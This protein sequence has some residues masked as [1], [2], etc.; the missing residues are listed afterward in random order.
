MGKS[1]PKAPAAPDP[2]ATAQAQGQMNK[3]TAIA[4]ANLNRIDQYTP[5]GSLTFSQIGTNP[6]GTP[7]YQSNQTYSPEQQK[8]YEQQTQVANAL[9]GLAGQNIQRVQDAQS[10]P[11]TYEG[12]T[13]LQTG[14]QQGQNIQSGYNAGGNIQQGYDAGGAIQNQIAGAGNIQNTYGSGG[15]IQK[16]LDFSQL[17]ALPG[18]G[19]FGSEAKRVQDAVYGQA[20]SRLDPAFEQ[21]Q[22][23]LATSLASKGVSENSEAYRRAMDQFARQ[24]TDAYNQATF[25]GIQAGGQEQS[26]LFGLALQGRQQGAAETQAGGAFA[27]AAQ[28]QAEAQAAARAGFGNQAQSQQFDQNAQSGAFYNAAQA[29]QNAQNQGAAAF[30][31]QAQ[32]QQNAQNAASAAFN[33]TAQGQ[34]FGQGMQNAAFNNQARQQQIQE[35]A[36]LRNLPL[37]DIAALMGTGGGVQ[38]PAFAD[39]AQT[40]VANTDYSGLVQNNFNNQMQLYNQQMQARNQGLGSIFGLAGSAAMAFS[41]RR[42]KNIIKAIGELPNGIKTYL[43]TYVGSS[44][45]QVGVMADEVFKVLP[46]AV[47]VHPS[48]YMMVDYGKVY[49]YGR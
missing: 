43:Y 13:P 9:S 21:Q 41:D 44:V 19:D 37:N 29:Q 15:N 11:F 38:N 42:L 33:N 46:E 30:G 17:S 4:N 35:A 6:D 1:T 48:G 25:S 36:Y 10:K 47:T 45:R 26:R 24:K 32:Q 31:N 8:L 39:Y 18:I 20:T 22:R 49:D 3:E 28:A 23:Q 12:M 2:V 16:G 5:Q 34:I 27:N 14:V 7:R 40:N